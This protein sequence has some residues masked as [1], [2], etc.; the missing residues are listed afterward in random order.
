V[1]FN[2]SAPGGASEV[3]RSGKAMAP[4]LIRLQGE[5]GFQVPRDLLKVLFGRG[6]AMP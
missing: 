6:P 5:Q 2:L 4:G 1:T 3:A